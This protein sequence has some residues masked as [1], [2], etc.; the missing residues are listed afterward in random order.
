[1]LP[2]AQRMTTKDFKGIKTRLV[3]RGAFFDVSVAPAGDEN[4]TT[5]F[6]CVIAKKRIKR[7]VDRNRARRKTYSLLNEV[8]TKAPLRVFIYPTKN[9]LQ[10]PHLS[11]QD[12]IKKAFATL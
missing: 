11:V 5:K 2:K 10:A 12:E 8:S 9:I 4:T 6:A 1:M 7:A 3:Y